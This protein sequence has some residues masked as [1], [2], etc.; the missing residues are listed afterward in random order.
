M[1]SKN[2][3]TIL[4][5]IILINISCNLAPGSYPFAELYEFNIN[6][7]ALIKS[8]EKFKLKNPDYNLPENNRQLDGKKNELDH[9]Y[10]VWFYYSNE[11]KIIKC[12]IRGNKIGFIGIGDGMNLDNYKEINNDY[13][14]NENTKEKEKFEK[15]IL[16][17]IRN[18]IN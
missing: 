15:L 1:K 6:E 14:K 8:V 12:W 11:N 2:N 18:E 16:N 5:T 13:S 9:W 10:H 17:K 7:K 3:L 4:L